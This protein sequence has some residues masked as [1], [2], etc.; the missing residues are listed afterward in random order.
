MHVNATI[1]ISNIL[2]LFYVTLKAKNMLK[3][4]ILVENR[5]QWIFSFYE[6]IVSNF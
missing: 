5:I 4:D 3:T 2:K 1:L 6:W